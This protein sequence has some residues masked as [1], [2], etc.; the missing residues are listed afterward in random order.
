MLSHH[1]LAGSSLIALQKL[2]SISISS[3]PGPRFFCSLEAE[4]KSGCSFQWCGGWGL[5]F[6]EGE[7]GEGPMAGQT[8]YEDAT[9][10]NLSAPASPRGSVD[11]HLRAELARHRSLAGW[12][13]VSA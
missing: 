1:C 3:T 4:P 5:C 9:S 7:W 6:Q 11:W 2:C 12:P 10:F 8:L 13:S